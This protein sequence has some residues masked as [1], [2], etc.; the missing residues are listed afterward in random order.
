MSVV[1]VPAEVLFD[2]ILWFD[3]KDFSDATSAG[4]GDGT[5]ISLRPP[6]GPTDARLYL[7]SSS[8]FKSISFALAE[9]GAG[10]T[11]TFEYFDGKNWVSL[12]K[13][14]HQLSDNTANL[15]ASG[16][17]TF[18]APPDWKP[19]EVN[20]VNGYWLRISTSTVPGTGAAAGG[21]FRE[22]SS[23]DL[24]DLIAKVS[25]YLEPRRLLTTRIHV[26][27]PRL[28]TIGV[29][30]TLAL[31]PD[32][33]PETVKR[34]ALSKLSQF[35][36]QQTWPFG[37]DVYVSEIYRLLDRIAGVDFVTKIHP[38]D[39]ASAKTI[40]RPRATERQVPVKGVEIL[41]T[42]DGEERC[43]R[44]GTELVAITLDPDELVNFSLAKSEIV[45]LP[46]APEKIET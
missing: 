17:I 9:A 41:T 26:V 33:V 5:I 4:T 7:G 10:Y 2:R 27:G 39:P 18:K 36:N 38:P 43:S 40:G 11:L 35:L 31:K 3:G 20:G 45:P 8:I 28:V 30:V 19:V 46:P 6:A 37:R 24:D 1:I 22:I 23:I 15:I 13:D 16:L 25:Q 14:K 29:H 12:T 42:D 32:A 34:D 21:I 44:Q